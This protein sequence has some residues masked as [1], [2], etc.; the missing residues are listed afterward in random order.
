MSRFLHAL[1]PRRSL[2]TA[3]AW[4]A[5][6]LSL[7]NAVALLGVTSFAVNSMLA[8][9]DALMSRFAGQLGTD[10]ER[11]MAGDLARLQALAG[12]PRRPDDRTLRQLL[13]QQPGFDAVELIDD[14]GRVVARQPAPVQQPKVSPAWD[15]AC[16]QA[17]RFIGL[18]AGGE[19]PHRLLLCTPLPD[20]E[21]RGLLAVRAVLSQ[22]RLAAIV[23]A[24]RDRA[25]PDER[26][27][28]LLLDE[29]HEVRFERP[30]GTEGR[31]VPVTLPGVSIQSS[32]KNQRRIVVVT[33]SREA[34]PTLRGLGVQVAV[35]QPSEE[36][37]HGG[38]VEEKLSAIS[39]LL[40][41]VAAIIGVAFAVRLTRRLSELSEQAQ[42]A[43]YQADAEIAEP[44]GQDEVAMLGRAF[45]QLLRSLREEHD[46]LDRL[47]QELEKRVVA[48]TREVERLAAD[49][50]Y[51]AVVR[52]RLRLAR[53][54]HDT[55]AHSMMEMLLE[56]RTL[57]MLHA[58]DPDKLGAE[59][60]RA[61]QV[62]AQG[63][64]EARDAVGQMRLN[65]VR[66]LG[67]GAALNAAVN[68]F[69]ER[70]GLTVRYNAAQRAASFADSRAE[71]VFRIA[72]EALRNID[73]HA[74]A[75]HVDICLQDGD[76]GTIV[77]TIADDGVGFDPALPHPGHYGV[78][79]IREQAQLID[80]E[81]DL[82][83]APGAGARLQLRLRV[84]PELRADTEDRPEALTSPR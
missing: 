77:L 57:R 31:G 58:H 29:R 54:L 71:T 33:V 8:Q 1:D 45:G 3:V 52:E 14:R 42:R 2:K 56:V 75:S 4:L 82:H 46:E 79:G 16:L 63:L 37:G 9:R 53:D 49:S 74:Q 27:Q 36:R 15:D 28:V 61:E 39:I 13:D 19:G 17:P 25:K 11:A 65:A 43:A 18:D 24:A 34:A 78:L 73:R 55:L 47:T 84:G 81:L 67:L 7:A 10:L 62:A 5:V 83:S 44:K 66:D 22:E 70:T 40:S 59:L 38:T 48:R 20:P 35:V 21:G 72:E 80:A 69:A 50:R 64:K 68:R 26:A 30:P 76:N 6:A 12:G 60:E 32:G 51:A 23:D 41:I